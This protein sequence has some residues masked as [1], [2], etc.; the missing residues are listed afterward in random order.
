MYVYQYKNSYDEHTDCKMNAFLILPWLGGSITRQKTYLYFIE[1]Y[2]RLGI[3]SRL[4][5]YKIEYIHRDS[6]TVV[7]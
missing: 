2:A 5:I 1:N 3:K 7:F 6:T 4:Q